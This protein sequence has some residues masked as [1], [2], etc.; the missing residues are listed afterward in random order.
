MADK[1]LQFTRDILT[2]DHFISY[3]LSDKNFRLFF[4][5]IQEEELDEVLAF[6]YR[7]KTRWLSMFNCICRFIR[8]SPAV[9]AENDGLEELRGIFIAALPAT[10]SRDFISQAY[11]H[12]LDTYCAVLLPLE[13][14]TLQLQL[15]GHTNCISSSWICILCPVCMDRIS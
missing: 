3:W 1:D 11:V 5:Q 4:A 2:L 13:T 10:M 15:Q 12:R 7:A 14:A 6:V 8:L 9:L